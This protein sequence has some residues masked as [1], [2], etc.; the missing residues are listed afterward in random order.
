MRIENNKIYEQGAVVIGSMLDGKVVCTHRLLMT[1][2]ETDWDIVDLQQSMDKASLAAIYQ[3]ATGKKKKS[4]LV[5]VFDGDTSPS[6]RPFKLRDEVYLSGSL[7]GNGYYFMA[8]TKARGRNRVIEYDRTVGKWFRNQSD[9]NQAMSM[10]Q[11]S[12]RSVIRLS[13]HG[14]TVILSEPTFGFKTSGRVV[15]FGRAGNYLMPKQDLRAHEEWLGLFG[16]SI[17]YTVAEDLR[18]SMV[19]SNDTGIGVTYRLDDSGFFQPQA[20]A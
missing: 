18:E 9:I 3:S 5:I 4:S 1:E 2:E 14:N 11:E 8:V 20:I 15:V 10:V 6:P 19:I 7:S 12:D 17:E 16:D 13:H